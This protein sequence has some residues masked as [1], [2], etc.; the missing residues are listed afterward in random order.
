[1]KI[2]FVTAGSLP[3][4]PVNGG[5]AENL[6]QLLIDENETIKKH[7]FVIFSCKN[8]KAITESQK[9]SHAIYEYIKRNDII[10]NVL[11]IATKVFVKLT[12][13]NYGLPIKRYIKKI[14]G[15]IKNKYSDCDYIVVENGNNMMQG[16]TRLGIPVIYHAHNDWVGHGSFTNSDAGCCR[17]VISVS[18]YISSCYQRL[19][20]MGGRKVYRLLNCVDETR[21]LMNNAFREAFRKQNGIKETD[22]LVVFAG[23][24]HPTK[25]VLEL[26]R[27]FA[28]IKRSDIFLLILGGT[29][30]SDDGTNE[31]MEKCK[32]YIRQI[33]TNVICTGYITYDSIPDYYSAAD[34]GIMPSIWEEPAGRVLTEMQAMGLPLI[35]TITGGMREYIIEGG[36]LSLEVANLERDITSNILMLADNVEMRKQLAEKSQIYA[37]GFTKRKYY[38]TFCKIL[39]SINEE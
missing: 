20:N 25:G 23:R 11:E 26:L 27:A 28:G 17:A 36:Y 1:M 34:V 12:G 19:E 15:M 29:N 10:D 30:Y 38:E 39:E 5:A 24:I 22:T 9:Y 7:D 16:L 4:P 14:S 21:F 35:C 2:I 8:E 33:G 31:Y 37:Q 3:M 6:V 32:E 13:K 18:D